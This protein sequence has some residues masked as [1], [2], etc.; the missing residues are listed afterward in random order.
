VVACPHPGLQVGGRC[1]WCCKVAALNGHRSRL[2]PEQ[3]EFVGFVLE[4]GLTMGPDPRWIP[5]ARRHERI[6]RQLEELERL[7]DLAPNW[8]ALAR[9]I[10]EDDE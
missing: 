8:F 3:A 6:D 4:P 7:K 2:T 1:Y 9:K 10:V 5:A